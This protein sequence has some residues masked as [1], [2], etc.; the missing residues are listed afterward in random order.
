MRRAVHL[1][2][3]ALR[4][5]G[6]ALDR[7][8][9]EATGNEIFNETFSRHRSLMNLYDKKIIAASGTFVAPNATLVGD[10]LLMDFASVWYGAVVRGDRNKVTIGHKSNIQDRAV[11]STVTALESEFP[12]AV[13]IGDFV[14]VGHGALLTSC[15]IGDKCLIGQG[16]IVSEGAEIGDNVIIAA[17]AVVLPNIIVPSGQLWAGNPAKYIRDVT[18]D[19]KAQFE[20]SSEKYS[21][22]SVEHEAE[23]LP[24]GVNHI[25][26]ERSKVI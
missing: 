1:A 20:E 8:A 26:A 7:F 6:Q 16:S 17:G 22:L 14:T 21:E 4:E 5:T 12:A 23:F 9:L 25:N 19:E 18:E 2:G 3:R 24:Y 15:T 11:I 13:T 10:V